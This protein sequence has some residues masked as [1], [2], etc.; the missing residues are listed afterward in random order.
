MELRGAHARGAHVGKRHASLFWPG[1]TYTWNFSGIYHHR[2]PRAGIPSCDFAWRPRESIKEIIIPPRGAIFQ[3]PPPLFPFLS[4]FLSSL[5]LCTSLVSPSSRRSFIRRS[6]C[7]SDDS[8]GRGTQDEP[9]RN[10]CLD[11]EARTWSRFTCPFILRLAKTF[12]NECIS[13]LHSAIILF[14]V[15]SDS[16]IFCHNVDDT[17][18][19]ILLPHS[20]YSYFKCDISINFNL[21]NSMK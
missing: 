13:P 6:F 11:R 1:V 20:T 8:F 5:P 17:F 9:A 2:L 14:A 12:V 7:K 21:W 15:D 4:F 10:S 16:K 3:W 19:I 18:K